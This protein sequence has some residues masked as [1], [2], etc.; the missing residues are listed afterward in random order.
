MGGF[1]SWP[2]VGES[3]RVVRSVE[4]REV[5]RQRTKQKEVETTEWKWCTTIP[6][7]KLATRGVV[8]FGHG[9]WAIENEGGFNEL[10]GEWNANHVYK[11][12]PTAIVSSWLLAMYAY[13][14][15]HAFIELNLKPEVRKQFTKRFLGLLI[16]S[17]LIASIL[18]D[19]EA[20]IGIGT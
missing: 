5:V 13:N 11:H 12:H 18:S 14:A 17:D 7:D 8:A 4:T 10:V 9:C 2:Q 1:R 20:E 6:V 3:V 19:G 15:F 16:M